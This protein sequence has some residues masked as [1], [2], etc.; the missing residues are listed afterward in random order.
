MLNLELALLCLALP[1]RAAGCFHLY[2]SW[3]NSNLWDLME[4]GGSCSIMQETL[5]T[6]V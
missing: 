4:L 3:L 2:T 6:D 1:G 5:I